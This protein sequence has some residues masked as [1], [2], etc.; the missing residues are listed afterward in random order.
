MPSSLEPEILITDRVLQPPL[1]RCS[2]RAG[3][4]IEFFGVVRG[5]EDGK[6]ISG[7]DYQAHIIM[8]RHQLIKVAT[9]ACGKFELLGMIVHHRIGFVP[10]GEA[11]LFLRVSAAHRHPAFEAAEWVIV[12]LKIRVPIWKH[13]VYSQQLQ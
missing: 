3:G 7:I 12:Q 6:T 4:V 11:S 2:L 8:A 13:A 5:E 9:E 1:E 10:A